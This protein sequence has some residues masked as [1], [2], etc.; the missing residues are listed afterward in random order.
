MNSK[1]YGTSTSLCE[2][3]DINKNGIWLIISDK[4]YFISFSDFPM[5]KGVPVDKI[6]KVDFY[7]PAHLRWEDI[8]ID[9]ELESLDNLEKYPLRFT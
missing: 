3:T 6:F 2:V 7:P 1:H 4:E 8:D 5:L 9:I